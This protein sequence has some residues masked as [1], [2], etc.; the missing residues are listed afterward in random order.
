MQSPARLKTLRVLM[1]HEA[2]MYRLMRERNEV[3]EAVHALEL[4][5]LYRGLSHERP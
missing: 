5:K 1:R 2:L 3:M 4:A